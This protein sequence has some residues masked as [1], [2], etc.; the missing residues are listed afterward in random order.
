MAK[1]E[2]P[3]TIAQA[4]KEYLD[5]NHMIVRHGSFSGEEFNKIL[6]VLNGTA[7]NFMIFNNGGGKVFTIWFFNE[8]KKKESKIEDFEKFIETQKGYVF[9]YKINGKETFIQKL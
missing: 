3:K 2:L 6:S 1:E 4:L 8:V 7:D 9:M 5:A